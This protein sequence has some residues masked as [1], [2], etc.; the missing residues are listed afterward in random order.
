MG[1]S[2]VC[3]LVLT[4]F[5]LR[6]RGRPAN[7]AV[8]RPVALCSCRRCQ[9]LRPLTGAA[10]AHSWP[11]QTHARPDYL[12]GVWTTASAAAV[13]PLSLLPPIR[14]QDPERVWA[15]GQLLDASR[16]DAT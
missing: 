9:S 12:Q 16:N 8:P 3:V 15:Y 5:A 6:C 7:L 2:S 13:P 4:D 1:D 11:A 14:R 10:S